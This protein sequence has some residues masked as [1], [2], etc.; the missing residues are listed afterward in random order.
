MA[1][2]HL[3]G[4]LQHLRRVLQNQ[5]ADALSDGQ[6]LERFTSHRDGAAFEALVQRHGPMVLSVCRRVLD[7]EHDAEDAFQATLLVL[8]RKAAS[9]RQHESV[10]SWLYGVAYRIAMKARAM[11]AQRAWHEKQ[12]LHQSPADALSEVV[13]R[14]LRPI[15]DEELN[16]LPEKY[17]APVVLCHLQGKT[18]EEAA[19]HLHWPLGTVKVRLARART[20]LQTRLTRRGCTLSAAAL[21]TLLEQSA[22]PAAVPTILAAST[23]KI[24]TLLATG[25]ATLASGISAPAAVLLEGMV[26]TLFLAKVKFAAAIILAAAVLTGGAGVAV[27]QT[28]AAK[29]D[30]ETVQRQPSGRGRVPNT[31][32]APRADI[33]PQAAEEKQPAGNEADEERVVT[34]RVQ[35]PD[36]Q[37]I[38]GAKLYLGYSSPKE[39]TYPVRATTGADGRFQFTFEPAKLDPPPKDEPWFQVLAMADRYGPDW[40][41]PGKWIR[42]ESRPTFAWLNKNTD[43]TL[44]L[45]KDLPVQGRILDLNGR[46][47]AG[48]TLRFEHITAYDDLDAFLQSVRDRKWPSVNSKSW[49]GPFPGK[50]NVL[51]IGP[52]GR[53]RLE[54]V[55]QDREVNFHL[56]GPGIQYGPF[57]CV[58]RELKAPVEPQNN[59]RYGP[60][61]LKAYGATLEHTVAPSRLIRGV[62]RDKRTGQ[63]VAGVEISTSPTYTTHRTQTD[64]EGRY[65]IQ[66]YVKTA[67]GYHISVSPVG[68]PYFSAGV[69][70]PDTPGLDPVQGDIELVSGIRVHG[71]V[72]HAATGQPIAGARVHYN[73]LYPNPFVARLLGPK[74]AG[75]NPYSWTETQPDGSYSLVVLPGPGAL[76]FEAHSQKEYFMPALVST[77]DL[78]ELFRD[79]EDHGNED[80]LRTQASADGMSAMG[81]R[82]FQHLLLLNPEEKA[83]SLTRDVALQPARTLRGKTIGPDDQPLRG[84]KAYYLRP[85]FLYGSLAEDTFTVLGLNPQRSHGLLF[86]HQEKNLAGAVEVR[87]EM[88]EPLIVRLEPCGSITGRLRDEDGQPAANTF[89][90]AEPPGWVT[91]GEEPPKVRT[92]RDGRFRIDGLVPGHRYQVRLG[93]TGGLGPSLLAPFTL[94]PSESKELGEVQAKAN[95]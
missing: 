48:A 19:R 87:G 50:P 36:G 6:L 8:V 26:R 23:V 94:K 35:G 31:L 81:Q 89:V 41:S 66:G 93:P 20:L 25:E 88:K 95:P 45:I 86:V 47:V 77:Q 60:I 22:A 30:K 83:E 29:Q 70:F 27:Q 53:F 12:V 16:R 72:T 37:P 9:I 79:N 39:L 76:G 62:V 10:G 7:D 74:G 64:Q 11:A 75:S 33:L 61:I 49:F 65:E 91:F 15:L 38:A 67:E 71:R 34:G 69:L 46:P 32:E 5:P 43:L 42:E 54:G 21:V 90:R 56:E 63:P 57:R 13:W 44:R 28:I 24:A 4:I 85:G 18:N 80:R 51:T 58:T 68:L 52:D 59:E 78:K 2:R 84:V 40:V 82:Q 17:R 92:D 73:P 14:D 55:G 1:A 3:Q